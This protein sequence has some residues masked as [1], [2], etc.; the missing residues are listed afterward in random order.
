MK[1]VPFVVLALLVTTN[2][3]TAQTTIGDTG[4]SPAAPTPVIV[5]LDVLTAVSLSAYG[6]GMIV[7][8]L[9]DEYRYPSL[10]AA[11]QTD[12]FFSV[13]RVVSLGLIAVSGVLNI[14][15]DD[16]QNPIVRFIPSAVAAAG[17]GFA[18][19]HEFIA[20]DETSR[21]HN[22]LFVGIPALVS[23]AIPLF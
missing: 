22:A 21:M 15:L 8:R 16:H 17:L 9:I 18:L 13:Q 4:T 2:S 20:P 5:R 7:A 1:Y 19:A 3:A 10:A 12:T 14:V 11:W 23:I 6:V